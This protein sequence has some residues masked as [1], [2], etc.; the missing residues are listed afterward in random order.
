MQQIKMQSLFSLKLSLTF[1]IPVVGYTVYKH[2]IYINIFL[3]F[4]LSVISQWKGLIL[5]NLDTFKSHE[6]LYNNLWTIFYFTNFILKQIIQILSGQISLSSGVTNEVGSL[7][8]ELN[9]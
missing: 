1:N 8:C 2:Y 5:D 9:W 7:C 6:F 3:Y 4:F